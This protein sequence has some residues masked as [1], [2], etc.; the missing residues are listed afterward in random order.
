[1]TAILH[2]LGNIA[3]WTAFWS[4]VLFCGLYAII[5]PWRQSAEGWHLMTF[6]AVIGV[7]FGWIAYRQTIHS[8][9][10]AGLGIEAPR[11]VIL[12]ALAALLVWRL[13]LLIRA[14]TRKR[15]R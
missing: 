14:Q 1:M 2:L 10:P 3:V 5:A 12:G 8:N 9:P 11:A 4:S 6:T 13:L 15:N 7:A